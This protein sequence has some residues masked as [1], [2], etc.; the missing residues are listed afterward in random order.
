[1]VVGA[2]SALFMT[3]GIVDATAVLQNY[4]SKNQLRDYSFAQIGWIFGVNLFLIFFGTTFTGRIF[5]VYGGRVLVTA[6]SVMVVSSMLLL[7][8]Y[9][10]MPSLHHVLG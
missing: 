8:L 9:S 2:F 7:G 1:V 6:G 5:D 3:F 10:S 4:L